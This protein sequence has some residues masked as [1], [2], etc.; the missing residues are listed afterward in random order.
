MIK[1]KLGLRVVQ[2]CNI[3]L[4]DVQV[5]EEHKLPGAT[6]FQNGTNRILKHSRPIVCWIAVGVAVG[7]YDNAIKYT[8][9]RKQFGKPIAGKDTNSC[10]VPTYSREAGQDHGQH[11]RHADA[12][13]EN[14][15][16]L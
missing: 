2:N 6:D 11:S 3:T 13:L 15:H 12:C 8:R 10:R 5:G 9:E 4:T 1:N 7:V 14:I 16:S